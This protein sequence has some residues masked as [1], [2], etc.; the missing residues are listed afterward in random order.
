MNFAEL[1][2]QKKE[3]K[4]E[5]G[6]K[7]PES[8]KI[9]IDELIKET[10]NLRETTSPKRVRIP[11]DSYKKCNINIDDLREELSKNNIM[12]SKKQIERI[13]IIINKLL[14]SKKYESEK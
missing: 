9:D 2:K 7:V 3:I 6:P 10:E 5:S 14:E 1:K 4:K 11:I 13:I 12:I 8:E